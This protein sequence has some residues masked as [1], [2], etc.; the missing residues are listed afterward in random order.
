M[1]RGD[2]PDRRG[3]DESMSGEAESDDVSDVWQDW[4]VALN[5]TAAEIEDWLGTDESKSVGQGEGESVGH[6]SGRRIVDLL[7]T[8]KADLT[9]DDVAHMRKVVGY[10]HRHGAQRPDGDVTETPGATR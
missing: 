3:Y 4:Q 2:G 8:K 1:G 9:D 5:M 6:R 7:H 10:V